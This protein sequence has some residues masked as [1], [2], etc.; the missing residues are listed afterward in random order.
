MNE[1]PQEE[2]F[3]AWALVELFGHAKIA[4]RV[5]EQTIAGHA[6]LRVD[7]PTVPGQPGYT[8]YYGAAAIY[9]ISP[10]DEGIATAM[11]KQY[12]PVPVSKFQLM[13]G[14]SPNEDV[15]HY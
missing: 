7:V 2:K 10:V 13:M 14:D 12:Q 15:H 8:R 4:G 5:S 9:S 3:E 1:P 11:V 6:F